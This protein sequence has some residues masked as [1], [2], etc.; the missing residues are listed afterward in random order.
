MAT[1][2][3]FAY[4]YDALMANAPYQEWAAYIDKVLTQYLGQNRESHIVLDLACGTG[5][6]TLP[7]AKMGYDMIGVDISPDMLAQA[8][9][10]AAD[11]SQK[12]LFLSQD[13]RE[14]DLY[15]TVDAAICVCDGINYILNEA[16]LE[17]IFK[18]IRMFLNPGG[19]FIFDMNTEY[20]FKEV[21]GDKSFAA[22]TKTAEYEWDNYYH[23][24]TGINEYRVTFVTGV[25]EPFIE[26]H[27]QRAYPADIICSLLQKSGFHTIDVRD[28][29]SD[30]LPGDECIRAV[31]IA[32]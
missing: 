26:V 15:G 29:Y 2:G 7:L 28:G 32:R 8:Q 5:N 1:Y 16:E 18:R 9:A 6:I 17:E 27:H 25:G 22:K 11:D 10:K 14:L 13:M 3:G 24:D 20:K 30:S 21:L 19:V 4:L 12:I 23:A 31:F